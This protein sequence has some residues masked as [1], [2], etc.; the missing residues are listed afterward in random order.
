VLKAAPTG[1]AI[2]CTGRSTTLRLLQATSTRSTATLED[3]SFHL[4][5]R[6]SLVSATPIS[7]ISLYPPFPSYR[8]QGEPSLGGI[9][10]GQTG[11][12]LSC[13]SALLPHDFPLDSLSYDRLG[14]DHM[15]SIGSVTAMDSVMDFVWKVSQRF[16][17]PRVDSQHNSRWRLYSSFSLYRTKGLVFVAWA[18]ERI[19]VG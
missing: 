11:V 12:T 1:T 18:T 14:D 16:T 8:C 2:W 19:R 9:A 7:G 4:T 6:Y 15:I 17:P 5:N 13:L 10:E 3:D